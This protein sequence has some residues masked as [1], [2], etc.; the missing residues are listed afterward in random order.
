MSGCEASGHFLGEAVLGDRDLRYSPQRLA[1]AAGLVRPGARVLQ[2]F[3]PARVGAQVQGRTRAPGVGPCAPEVG[4]PSS[5]L[6]TWACSAFLLALAPRFR[7][8][9]FN[10]GDEHGGIS[11]FNISDAKGA[12]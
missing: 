4:R 2:V 10:P 11:K 5:A 8:W 6:A 7:N 12:L 3:I 1:L 9:K